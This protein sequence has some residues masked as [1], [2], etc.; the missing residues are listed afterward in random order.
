LVALLIVGVL[1]L[2]WNVLRGPNARRS[3]QGGSGGAG[4]ILSLEPPARRLLR[5]GFGLLW[6]LDGLLQA[7]AAMPLGMVPEVIQPAASS[8]PSWVQH[9]M[10]PMATTWTYHP[11]IAATA[12]VW[13]QLGIGIWLLVSPRG[14][15]SRLAGLASVGWG[16]VVW[17]FGEAFGGIF[18]PGLTF[19][20]G[21]PGAVLLYCAAGAVI[22]LPERHWQSPRLGRVILGTTGV[23]FLGMALLQAWP[24]R[25]FWQGRIGH[26][27]GSLGSIVQDM[28]QTPQPHFLS[29][30]VTS[31]GAF[32]AAHGF[33]VNLF[34]VIAL[35]VSGVVFLVARPPA[36]LRAT[37]VAMTFLCLVD[38]VLI[39]DLGFFG[40]VGTDP[41]S[42]IPI[43]LVFIAGY[44]ALSPVPAR[45]DAAVAATREGAPAEVGGQPAWQPGLASL[46]SA[47][48]L[49]DTVRQ[50][51]DRWRERLV[52]DPKYAFRSF[53]AL[54]AVGV[55]L[56]GVAP[57]AA[58]TTNPNADPILAE[59][60]YGQPE[61]T[62]VPAPSF[63]LVDQHGQR[64]T[65]ADLRGKTLALTFLNSACTYQGAGCPTLR[66]L[67]LSDRIL[68]A[69]ADRVELVAVSADPKYVTPAELA[70]FDRRAGLGKMGNFLYLTGSLPEL[71]RVLN[72]Y[73]VHLSAPGANGHYTSMG[74]PHGQTAYVID[75]S[76]HTRE[77]LTTG[78]RGA[79]S[80]A[81]ASS[82]GVALA[83]AIGRVTR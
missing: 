15:G 41:N 66:E 18:A 27:P 71:R 42:M 77:V 10:N 33:G 17:V 52:A 50:G 36:L 80:S 26:D 70:A 82:V 59:S 38:W 5:I 43:V 63:A 11:I 55:T 8:S 64:V 62:N 57:M 44:L 9:V 13:I 25:G 21:A 73:A 37:V 6:V 51:L 45:A 58:A 32:D 40:G 7:Q 48:A 76:G 20:F 39:E 67:R 47:S 65:L 53:A 28:S 54:G 68:G 56:I 49:A 60:V 29:S 79:V 75:G 22:A 35:A 74:L 72:D 78:D 83:N 61:T 81:M 16:I 4:E 69:K 23:F 30:W 1:A 2:G 24:G 14:N 34:A 3:A 46:A 19:L 31:F 12:A